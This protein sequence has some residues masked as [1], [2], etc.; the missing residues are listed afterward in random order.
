MPPVGSLAPI[1]S[2]YVAAMAVDPSP[3]HDHRN[4]AVGDAA[5]IAGAADY[6]PWTFHSGRSSSDL[7]R[8]EVARVDN[9]ELIGIAA[10]DALGTDGRQGVACYSNHRSAHRTAPFRSCC[11]G[12]RR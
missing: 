10:Y 5:N 6:V 4:T 7:G 2:S 3:T 1:S 12:A 11:D 9:E 8:E